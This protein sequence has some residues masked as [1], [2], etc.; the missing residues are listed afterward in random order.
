MRRESIVCED[1][2]VGTNVR[3]GKGVLI[4]CKRVELGDNVEIGVEADENFRDVAGVRI[5][6]ETLTL[7][8][9]TRIGRA[10]LMKGGKI[11]FG[12]NCQL[13]GRASIEVRSRLVVGDAS[14][15]GQNWRL[16]GVDVVIGERM[17]CLD[18]VLIG[19]GSAFEVYSRLRIGN[20][21]H[22]GNQCLINTA[23][24]VHIG[25]QVGLGTRTALYTHGSYL[26]ILEGYPVEFGE[27]EIGDKCWLPGATVNPGVHIGAG[28]VVGVGSV[29]TRDLP[30]GCLAVGVPARVIKEHAFPREVTSGEK[31]RIMHGLL[32]NFAEILADS[33]DVKVGDVDGRIV[34][35][36]SERQTEIV[37]QYQ[38]KMDCLR[39]AAKDCRRILA[40]AFSLD[41]DPALVA[42]SDEVTLFDL[43]RLLIIGRCDVLSERL[44]NE[45]RRYGIRFKYRIE[46]RRYVE[47]GLHE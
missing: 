30:A 44:R 19:G 40:L 32:G 42:S 47:R 43:S 28:S 14:S 45:L 15:I 25:N 22:L 27:I 1:S 31:D 20:D 29:V 41:Y 33:F 24:P 34:L 46:N 12:E 16:S 10:I 39:A 3:I 37:Y 5:I 13:G 36:L 17:R 21:C 8:S 18:D 23:R 7:G 2:K 38:M 35:S 6:A 11:T 26:S 9:N 4:S